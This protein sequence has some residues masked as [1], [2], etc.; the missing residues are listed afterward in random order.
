MKKRWMV[1]GILV[2][3]VMGYC[4][5]VLHKR[6]WEEHIQAVVQAEEEAVVVDEEPFIFQILGDPIADDMVR[7]IRLSY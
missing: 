4:Q 1:L 7:K 5:V 6:M 3:L 2:S